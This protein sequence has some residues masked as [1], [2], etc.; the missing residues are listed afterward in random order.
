[1]TPNGRGGQ[2]I[3]PRT[4]TILFTGDSFVD[5]S[6]VDPF[7]RADETLDLSWLIGTSGEVHAAATPDGARRAAEITAEAIAGRPAGSPPVAVVGPELPPEALTS[8]FDTRVTRSFSLVTEFPRSLSDTSRR[9]WRIARAWGLQPAAAPDPFLPPLGDRTVDVLAIHDV[10]FAYRTAP[11]TWYPADAPQPRH[12]VLSTMAPF[13]GN[14]LLGD[15]LQR[16]A[17]RLTV[18]VA[19]MDLRKTGAP[20]GYPLSWERTAEEVDAAVR[21]HAIGRAARVVVQLELSGAVVVTR[22][23][24]TTLVF[25]PA[26]S[27]GAWRKSHPGM[28]VGYPLCYLAALAPPLALGGDIDF[29]EAVR[30]GVAAARALHT[31]GLSV[32]T[33]SSGP[34]L[35]GPAEAVTRALNEDPSDIIATYHPRA[36]GALSIIAG[37][38]GRDSLLETAERLALGGPR[39]LPLA[40]PSR[41]SGTGRR[42]TARRSRS[43]AASAS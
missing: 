43:C 34:T 15:L 35:A 19:V 42:S 11:G 25:D 12:V 8:P 14:D 33:G 13:A 18:I 30:R 2:R 3:A 9:A 27:E 23:G 22:D 39:S 32:A 21:G 5:W 16:V 38:L 10:G 31:E 29:P 17:D 4:A 40:S 36:D 26:S 28:M 41:P 6:I 24:P 1:M 37:T 7:A 20:I